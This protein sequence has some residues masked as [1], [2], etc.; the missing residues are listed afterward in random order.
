MKCPSR[1]WRE[2]HMKKKFSAFE[3][4]RTLNKGF[5]KELPSGVTVKMRI[6]NVGDFI[7]RGEMPSFLQ[8]VAFRLTKVA[9]GDPEAE[10][11]KSETDQLRDWVV[12]QALI[13]PPC[14]AD[15]DLANDKTLFVEEIP[16]SDREAISL[17]AL[18]NIREAVESLTPFLKTS[19]AVAS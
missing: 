2:Y 14:T 10:C 9:Q 8:D 6:V 3:L 18:K 5:E 7:R 13:D 16:Y 17:A 4:Y 19:A 12:A 1:K 15:P 11:S